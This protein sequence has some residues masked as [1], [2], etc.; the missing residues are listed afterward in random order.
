MD[1]MQKNQS[2]NLVDLFIICHS[3]QL[4]PYVRH[5]GSR[6]LQP[7]EAQRHAPARASG[8]FAYVGHLLACAKL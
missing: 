6:A 8:F 4:I 1:G 5:A 3:Y 2:T 7:A